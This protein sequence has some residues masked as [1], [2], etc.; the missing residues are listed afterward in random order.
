MDGHTAP[1]DRRAAP[2]SVRIAAELRRDIAAGR[3]RPGERVPSTREIT[4]RWGVAMATATKVITT[5]RQ[6]GLVRTLPG[7]GTVVGESRPAPRTAPQGPAAPVRPGERRRPGAAGTRLTRTAIVRT[8][9]GIADTEGLDG[10][11]MRRVA[12]E[13]GAAPMALYRHVP[14]KEDLLRL[15]VEAVF[16]EHPP[17][18]PAPEGMREAL[19]AGARVQWRLCR[20]HPWV[21]PLM[22]IARPVLTPSSVDHTEW[23]VRVLKGHG[24]G[25]PEA[26]NAVVALTGYVLGMAAQVSDDTEAAHETGLR[27]AQWW[28]AREPELSRLEATG[29]YPHLFAYTAG[30]PDFDETFEFGLEGFLAGLEARLRTAAG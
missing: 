3:L 12:A 11:S 18:E 16:A 4:R 21:V 8:A 7:V 24:V 2:V 1:E 20:R 27:H 28:A 29:R 22:S 25:A 26:L 13:L 15:M 14:A 23:A 19:A 9:V 6:E 5:L 17:P 30:P 10:V